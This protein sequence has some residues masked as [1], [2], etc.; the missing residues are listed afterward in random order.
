[1]VISW[2][3]PGL[4]ANVQKTNNMCENK[5]EHKSEKGAQTSANNSPTFQKRDLKFQ[6]GFLKRQNGALNHQNEQ[7]V[8]T[9]PETN[10]KKRGPRQKTQ[11]GALNCITR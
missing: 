5:C 1:M 8:Q 9:T 2:I 11:N 7:K 4:R 3:R 10:P 6:N